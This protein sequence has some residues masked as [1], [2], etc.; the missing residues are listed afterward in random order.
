LKVELSKN[1]KGALHHW[2]DVFMSVSSLAKVWK[3]ISM[4]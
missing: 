2:R 1:C 4:F 3:I